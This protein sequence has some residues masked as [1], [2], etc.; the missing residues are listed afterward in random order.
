MQAQE[1]SENIINN[2]QD[3]PPFK[4]TWSKSLPEYER[5]NNKREKETWNISFDAFSSSPSL[6]STPPS[7][8][9]TNKVN[10]SN[11]IN[12]SNNNNNNNATTPILGGWNTSTTKAKSLFDND[13]QNKK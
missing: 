12:N 1:E 5:I 2:Y 3:K 6:S 9:N 4:R 11:N 10:D 7:L 8:F 13:E